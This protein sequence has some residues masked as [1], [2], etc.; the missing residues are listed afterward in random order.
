MLPSCG[1]ASFLPFNW[2]ALVIDGFTTR[3]APPDAAPETIL[4]A[5]PCDLCHA[6]IAGFGPTEPASSAPERS[7]VTSSG[8]ALKV[9]V[10]S[11]TFE[12]RSRAKIPRST[13]SNAVACVM[14]GK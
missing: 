4:I 14:F 13:P 5:V 7:A 2:R 12:P 10:I 9:A 1:D 11:V 6:L 3:N 8:P